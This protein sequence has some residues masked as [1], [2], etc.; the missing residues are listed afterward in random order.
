MKDV[1]L[2][3]AFCPDPEREKILRDLVSFLS[4]KKEKLDII[5]ISHTPIPEDISRQ[6]YISIY[7]SK[8]EIVTDWD[9][10]N[11]PWFSPGNDGIIYSSF[12]SGKS[13]LLAVW[14]M[15]IMG[16]S[17][18]KMLEYEKIHHIE[19]D[20]SLKDIEEILENSLLLD[21]YDSIL[22]MENVGDENISEIMFGSFQ[23]IRL[24]T[25]T[26][27]LCKLNEEKIKDLV[28]NSL[29]KSSEPLLCDLLTE[30]K[31]YLFKDKR[32]LEKNGNKFGIFDGQIG[33]KKIPWAVPFF[34]Y[35]DSKV[36]FIVWNTGNSEVCHH[37]IVNFSD[38]KP[39][40]KTTPGSWRINDV[41]HID[42]IESI[43]VME[44]NSIRDSFTLST[45]DQKEIFKK[46]SYRIE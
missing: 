35:T 41:G 25:L 10:L 26:P 8:N 20:C 21:E 5:L 40:G 17:L 34:D 24:D 7:D 33:N 2:I 15:M 44:D 18:S 27:F 22:Y 12:L 11:K 4:E 28:R 39:I 23:S 16:F 32:D 45:A 29:Y 31:K 42:D 1:V 19:Y 37:L 9:L 6:T 14:R 13:T 36:K 3:T 46:M 30:G 38:F 43:V